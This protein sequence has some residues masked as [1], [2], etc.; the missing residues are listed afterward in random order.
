FNSAMAMRISFT[1]DPSLGVSNYNLSWPANA[2]HPDDIRANPSRLSQS[3]L[4]GPHSVG[5]DSL[6]SVFLLRILKRAVAGDCG[7][8]RPRIVAGGCGED[9]A[10]RALFH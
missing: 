7:Q 5:H 6:G 10:G 2:G 9:I 4:D 1:P 3:Q 8:K